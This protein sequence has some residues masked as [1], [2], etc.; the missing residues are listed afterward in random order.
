MSGYGYLITFGE[1]KFFKKVRAR[2]LSQLKGC[3]PECVNCGAIE[4]LTIDHK[5]PKSTHPKARGYLANYQL[6][7]AKCNESKGNKI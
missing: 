3:L 7:C 6:M 4:N 2:E 5:L 1:N